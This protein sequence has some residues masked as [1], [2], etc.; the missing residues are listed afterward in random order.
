MKDKAAINVN[1]ENVLGFFILKI[2]IKYLLK[3]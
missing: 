3:P 1:V 2:D